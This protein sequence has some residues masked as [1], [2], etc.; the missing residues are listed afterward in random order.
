MA[1]A[2]L[3]TAGAALRLSLTRRERREVVVE[4]ELLIAAGHHTVVELLIELG[5]EGNSSQRHGLTALEDSRSVGH[6]QRADLAPDRTDLI[7]LTAIHTQALVEDAAAHGIAQHVAPVA[8]SLSV[9]LLEV[10]LGEVGVS[11]VVLLEEVGQRLVEG[12]VALLLR[13]GLVDD[14]V[15]GLIELVVD[16]LAQILV[17]D[18]VVV[19][20]L[21]VGTELL[22][23]LVLQVAHGL[24]SLLGSLEGADKVLFRHLAHLA[25]H[26]HQVVFGATH[27]D[28]EVGVFHL[29]KCRVNDVLAIDAC[30]TA[31]RD[32]VLKRNGRASHGGRGC[33]A[34]QCVGLVL[35]IT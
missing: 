1:V 17:V 20:T 16:L 19:F 6:G 26:H 4:Q 18:F 13:Q 25:F 28:V 23:E 34:C 35:S 14:I 12:V 33:K 30:H 11:S 32:G 31:L 9:L 2:N 10:L 22:G 24:D 5:A 8:G 15:S 27:H 29:L 7:G 21:L 3:T